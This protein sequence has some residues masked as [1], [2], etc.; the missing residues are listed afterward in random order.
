LFRRSG[1]A[2][3]QNIDLQRRVFGPEHPT[4]LTSIEFEAINLSHEGRYGEAEKLF[5]EVIQT[6]SKANQ[7]G[8]LSDAWYSF[9]RGATIARHRDE[10]LEYL[11]Q[12][13][14]YGF[15][16]PQWMTGDDELKSLRGEPRFEAL[17]AKAR[18]N[19]TA[20]TH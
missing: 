8:V 6:A 14:H 17:V 16:Q 7:P 2:V 18:Q 20:T 1:E 9:A 12:A 4:T 11:R 19:A 5:R 13:I 3:P 10:A 15:R